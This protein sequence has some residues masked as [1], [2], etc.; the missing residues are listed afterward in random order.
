MRLLTA[1]LLITVSSLPSAAQILYVNPDSEGPQNGSSWE[2]GYRRIESALAVASDG[3]EIWI[4]EGVYRTPADTHF[5]LKDGVALYGGFSGTETSRE[6]RD[7]DVYPSIIRP[8]ANERIRQNGGLM[9]ASG[10]SATIDGLYLLHG[11]ASRGG[12]IYVESSDIILSHVV[13]EDAVALEA[14]GGLYVEGS[15]L[16]VSDSVVRGNCVGA[17]QNPSSLPGCRENNIQNV[18]QG[19]GLYVYDTEIDIRRSRI[20]SN[21]VRASLHSS[22]GGLFV[23]D[24]S[25]CIAESTIKANS[26]RSDDLSSGGGIHS[27]ASLLRVYS[28]TFESNWARAGYMIAR[29]SA[30]WFDGEGAPNGSLLVNVLA[31]GNWTFGFKPEPHLTRGVVEAVGGVLRVQQ[32]TFVSNDAP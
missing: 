32:S 24:S 20:E 27:Q 31:I 7:P 9:F 21:L 8:R 5:V 14:G 28:T 16:K 26:V 30:V 25:A 6:E 1:V 18:S 2:N 13:I 3:D 29:G 15:V 23:L 4:R 17:F 12:A 19:G 11:R 22:G 10:I